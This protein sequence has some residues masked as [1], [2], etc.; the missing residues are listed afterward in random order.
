MYIKS[1]FRSPPKTPVGSY[2]ELKKKSKR[3]YGDMVHFWSDYTINCSLDIRIRK[4]KIY[5]E[6]P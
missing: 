4:I 6:V 1:H 2:T 3:I 5:E